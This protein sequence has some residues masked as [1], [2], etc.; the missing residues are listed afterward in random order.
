MAAKKR[1]KI[2]PESKKMTSAKDRLKRMEE[3]IAPYS[4]PATP[5]VR[6]PKSE[7]VPGDFAH[8]RMDDDADRPQL[9]VID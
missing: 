9:S 6:A 3:V 8:I 5:Q 7:W 2:R 4:R 1:T